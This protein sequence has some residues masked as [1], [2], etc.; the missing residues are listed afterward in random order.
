MSPLRSV[1]GRLALA[2]LVIVAGVLAIVYLIVV[3]SFQRSLEN[4]E[5]RSL[6][7]SIQHVATAPGFPTNQASLQPY[8]SGLQQAVNA[9]VA[10]FSQ[11][12][13]KGPLEPQADSNTE[14][15]S[16][17][18]ERD[19]VALAAK[20]SSTLAR[21]T[22]SRDGQ[23][24]AEVAYPD[25]LLCAPVLGAAPRPAA[26]GRCGASACLHRR[27]DRDAL[28]RARRVHR[29]DALRAATE[30]PR[31]GRRA[32]RGR[33]LRRTGGRSD[34]RRG[35]S[36]GARVR[37]DA[38]SRSPAST[39]RVGSSSRMPRT[40]FAPRSSRSAASS[41]CWTSPGSTRRRETSSSLR[42]GSRW[43]V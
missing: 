5:L 15:N 14:Q 16:S 19:P 32:D 40:S 10:V 9:R 26:N 13:S 6:A 27:G 18:L 28:R 42:C 7:G 35:R 22:V 41:S 11:L 36:A 21:G 43:R 1:G 24:F 17:V 12:A 29:R 37:A 2:L 25:Q 38:A 3:P 23:L 8:V 30:A 31:G 20:N 34:R 33:R 39:G 4:A